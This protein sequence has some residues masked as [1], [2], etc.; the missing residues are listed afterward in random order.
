MGSR[1]Y[2]DGVIA[3][4]STT[5]SPGSI[6]FMVQVAIGVPAIRPNRPTHS[7]SDT[8]D[9]QN[10]LRRCEDGDQMMHTPVT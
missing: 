3:G 9:T 4:E 8:Y 7:S 2:I 10:Q 1:R 6:G 5:L